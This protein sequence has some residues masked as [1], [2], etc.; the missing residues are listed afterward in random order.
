MTSH[1]LTSAAADS[2]AAIVVALGP[3]DQ[4][5]PIC[6]G[7]LLPR[8][9]PPL[10]HR[11]RRHLAT[12]NL[13]QRHRP[14]MLPLSPLLVAAA[15]VS[16]A[17][18][19]LSPPLPCCRH[20]RC[21]LGACHLSVP[22]LCSPPQISITAADALPDASITHCRCRR[23]WL[24]LLV[25]AAPVAVA[26]AHHRRRCLADATISAHFSFHSPSKACYA[27]ATLCRSH[28]CLCSPTAVLV[29]RPPA[30]KRKVDCCL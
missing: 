27:L 26:S 12:K 13:P 7:P 23:R 9:L 10:P 16:L 24:P 2:A 22:A 1:C 5:R 28:C 21:G 20:H 14:S 6:C 19:A 15:S 11:C 17:T 29:P 25:A 18:V 4:P 30:Y 3:F 8:P